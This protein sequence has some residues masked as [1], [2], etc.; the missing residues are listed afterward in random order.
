[1]KP[2]LTVISGPASG[3]T[4]PLDTGDFSIGRE[5]SNTLCLSDGLVSRQ[6]C[7]V[8]SRNRKFILRDLGST[9]G[10][11]VN[12]L[13]IQEKAL[14][15]GD[16]ITIGNSSLVFIL[17][18]ED[19]LVSGRVD[20]ELE[21]K[22]LDALQRLRQEDTVYLNPG[23]QH[24]LP[25][26]AER[27]AQDLQALLKISQAIQSIRKVEPLLQELLGLILK[28]IPAE[29]GAILLGT[30]PDS[31]SHVFGWDRLEGAGRSISVSRTV[32]RQV[33][34]SGSALFSDRIEHDK[35]LQES[36]SLE[37][38]KASSILCVPIE[39]FRKK[40]GAIYLESSDP[41]IQFDQ[42]HLHF[43][44]AAA[45]SAAV[46]LQNL[47]RLER[48]R[49]E[50]ERLQNDIEAA[51][52]MVGKSPAMRAVFEVISRVAATDSTV[53]ILGE[54]GTGKEL[55]ARAIHQ[56]SSRK[57]RPFV[58]INCANLSGELLES[59]LF[60]HEK[61]AFTGA[62]QAKKGKLEVADG[63]TLLLD[64]VGELSPGSQAKILRVL[65]E[66]TFERVGGTKSVKVDV[67]VV[68]CTNRNLQDAVREGAFRSDLFYRLNVIA[69]EMPPLRDRG[70]DVSLLAEH[71]L[72]KIV[73]RCKS[74]ARRFSEG[75]LQCLAQ[76][77]WP[78]NVR[79]LE[80]AIER[81]VVLGSTEEILP[82]D[83]PDT[84]F[85]SEAGSQF[86]GTY[87]DALREKK[88]ELILNAVMASGGNFTD[89][90][91]ILGLHPNY[92]HRL[93]RNLGL[94]KRIASRLSGS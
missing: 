23:A 91:K 71:L 89:A 6:H 41:D 46:T 17:N 59:E 11:F 63:G 73:S 94:R 54:P 84:I 19:P 21:E 1:M 68:A 45:S 3:A 52:Q 47:Q 16:R 55:S 76:Y 48:L 12:G 13:A 5:N 31:F 90:A 82:E 33:M 26:P 67:R 83:L 77:S 49:Q 38:S 61:G 29:R 57:D 9:N 75:A 64:E 65:Q 87:A 20:I 53:L 79:E 27:L 86:P 60:G 35:L 66:K 32:L 92:L 40:L 56:N 80:N 10:S 44:T 78:G 62:V 25:L 34:E 74:P 28:A 18:E 81:A 7:V 42:H 93:V 85:E 50:N 30:E 15:H 88:R 72:R 36:A 58:A 37:I 8:E 22:P 43:L 4:Y 14:R 2:R 69:L 70:D 51:F 39:R 24:F